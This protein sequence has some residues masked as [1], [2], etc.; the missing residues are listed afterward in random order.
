[1]TFIYDNISYP[2]Q[3]REIGIEGVAVVSFVVYKDGSI[4]DYKLLKDPGAGLGREAIRVV[5]L[6]NQKKKIWTPGKQRGRAVNVR[7]NMPVRF[8]LNN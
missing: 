2:E 5:K 6:M 4:K 3:A 1:M 8:K 7:M